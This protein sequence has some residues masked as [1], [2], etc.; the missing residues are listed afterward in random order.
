[1]VSA[2]YLHSVTPAALVLAT[3]ILPTIPHLA[4]V[5]FIALATSVLAGLV[6]TTDV[7]PRMLVGSLTRC[8]GGRN[9]AGRE[10]AAAVTRAAPQ[11]RSSGE[12]SRSEIHSHIATWISNST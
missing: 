9:S 2:W 8:G 12:T 1:M 11:S 10:Q 4:L 6:R 7:A 3:A 5:A